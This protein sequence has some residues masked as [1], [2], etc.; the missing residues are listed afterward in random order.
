VTG[1]GFGV[2]FTRIETT[3]KHQPHVPLGVRAGEKNPRKAGM[4]A[5]HREL[6]VS[7]MRDL[8]EPLASSSDFSGICEPSDPG[9]HLHKQAS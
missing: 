3:E 7:M 8:V 2:H 9:I 5:F 4:V 6:L 1:S